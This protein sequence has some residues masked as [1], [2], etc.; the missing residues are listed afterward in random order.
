MIFLTFCKV[1]MTNQEKM[2][3][4]IHYYGNGNKSEFARKVEV[5]P[6]TVAGWL[7]FGRFPTDQIL[8]Y[9]KEINPDWLVSGEGSMLREGVETQHAEPVNANTEKLLKMIEVFAD[10]S[11]SKFAEKAGV[12]LS[13][14]SNWLKRGTLQFQALATA[15]P[16]NPTWLATGKGSM[17]AA[18]TPSMHEKMQRKETLPHVPTTAQAGTLGGISESVREEDCERLP[19]IP[20]LPAYDFTISVRGDSMQPAYEG[21]DILA[22][23]KVESF[24]EWG[25]VYIVDTCDGVL[26]K[27]VYEEDDEHFRFV[28]YNNKY[29]DIIVDKTSVY[30]FFR[31]IGS[32]RCATM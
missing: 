21:G 19:R 17:Y 18:I 31:I 30:N 5:G 32:V 27:Q 7:Q 28:S 29:K 12:S 26:L 1:D 4:L 14:L 11:K 22:V 25:K 3:A 20:M 23:K 2:L 13:V 9:C 10:G 16:V 8:K 24:L 6:S 15:F